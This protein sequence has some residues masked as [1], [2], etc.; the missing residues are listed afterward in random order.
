MKLKKIDDICKRAIACLIVVQ[1]CDINNNEDY[2]S[3]KQ[4]CSNFA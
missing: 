3:S 4:F 2:V 1:L